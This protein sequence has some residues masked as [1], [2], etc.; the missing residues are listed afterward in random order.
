L[1]YKDG[2]GFDGN[3]F[4]GKEVIAMAKDA[5]SG[6]WVRRFTGS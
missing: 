5:D 1:K 3:G 6:L 4:D 2:N